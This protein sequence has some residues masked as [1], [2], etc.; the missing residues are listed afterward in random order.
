MIAS[1][2]AEMGRYGQSGPTMAE[3]ER[4]SYFLRAEVV[5]ALTGTD[6]VVPQAVRQV[7]TDGGD[8]PAPRHQRW[9]GVVP[10]PGVEQEPC[11]RPG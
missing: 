5:K 1:V 4:S 8:D 10:A 6:G 3:V 7:G 9:Y 11:S 2:V